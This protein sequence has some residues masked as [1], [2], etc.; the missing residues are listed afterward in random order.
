[1]VTA[2]GHSGPT[3]SWREAARRAGTHSLIIWPPLA[4]G[5]VIWAGVQNHAVAF[6]FSHAYLPAAHAVLAGRS[7]FPAATAAALAP[8]TAFV[9]PPL[10]AYLA[11]PFTAIST[12]WA[13]SVATALAVAAVISILL[14]VGVRDWRCYMVVFLWEPTYSAIQTGNVNL[15]LALGLALVWR[16]RDRPAT[17][18][19]I[20]GAMFALKPFMWPVLVWLVCTRRF[21]TAF[22]GSAAAAFFVLAPWAAIGFAGL[23][24]YPHL[25]NVLSKVEGQDAY[26]IRAL[27]G[28]VAPTRLAEVVGILVGVAALAAAVRVGARDERRSF[29]L[30]VAG[31]LLLS[32]IVWM[33]YFV[34]LLVVVGVLVGRF[35]PAWLL[36]LLFWISPQV[37]NG[38]AWQ[39]A[40]C[41]AVGA[42][43]VWL[44]IRPRPA[45]GPGRATT[46]EHPLVRA[47][48]SAV[49]HQ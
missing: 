10:T 23:G 31:C 27:L 40:A 3:R 18:A 25:L 16:Y 8:R 44:A 38:A 28:G 26:T 47:A 13:E 43:T 45:P 19:L 46:L 5:R 39:T 20:T 49:A 42:A 7:P 48:R 33:D 37:G 12:G 35:G 15:L 1:M 24:R 21:R 6:D 34:L 22:A 36:P 14:V 41:L 29:A 17:A 32:P 9:Y 2:A 30:G 4:I 11:A